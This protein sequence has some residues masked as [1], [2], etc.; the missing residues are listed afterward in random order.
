MAFMTL[1]GG[2]TPMEEFRSPSTRMHRG[3][4]ATIRSK[5]PSENMTLASKIN[6]NTTPQRA[7]SLRMTE[8]GKRLIDSGQYD[9]A[10]SRIER[11]LA[12]DASNP[13]VYYFL[14]KAH[15]YLFDYRQSVEFLDVAESLLSTHGF[16]LGEI[17]SL[18][19]QNY[20]ELGLL[21]QAKKSFTAALRF[22]PKNQ[23]ASVGLNRVQKRMKMP[24]VR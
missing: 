11:A 19:G 18:K 12:I 20:Q 6:A 17:H 10:L 24:A 1:V 3:E 21:D 15:F 9:K 23:G 14:G 7:A 2:C 22:N 4:T 16:W 13:Y 5:F 8:E